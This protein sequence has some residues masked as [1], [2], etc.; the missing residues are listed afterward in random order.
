M[1]VGSARPCVTGLPLLSPTRHVPQN[2]RRHTTHAP[3]PM[4]AV[5]LCALLL[6]A[7]SAVA[8][9]AKVNGKERKSARA[10]AL[11]GRSGGGSGVQPLSLSLSSALWGVALSHGA[12]KARPT[13]RSPKYFSLSNPL[14][15]SPLRRHH[16]LRD[17]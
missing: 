14:A 3:S 1:S 11:L 2:A 15:A 17:G 12:P 16:R 13:T 7:S 9:P 4:K 8:A 10:R 6:V 5:I